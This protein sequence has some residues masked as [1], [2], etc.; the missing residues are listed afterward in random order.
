[1]NNEKH[2]S[3]MLGKEVRRVSKRTAEKLFLSGATLLVLS[4]NMR[5][6]NMWQHPCPLQ[7]DNTHADNFAQWVNEFE[8]YNC[9]SVRGY[10]AKF[11]V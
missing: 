9:D 3:Q 7:K 10:Y 2:Y 11:Y 6:G 8:Y 5:F 1:M 4:S